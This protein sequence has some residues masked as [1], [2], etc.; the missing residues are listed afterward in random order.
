MLQAKR[1]NIHRLILYAARSVVPRTQ[2][3]DIT[4][5]FLHYSCIPPPFFLVT[6]SLLQ[7]IVYLYYVIETGVGFSLTK[8]API[9]S[10]LILNPYKKLEFWRYFT[11]MFI[12]IG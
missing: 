7:L 4:R 11:Y 1:M 3:T 8:P 6:I 5:Y 9:N 12:H 10:T 2:Q